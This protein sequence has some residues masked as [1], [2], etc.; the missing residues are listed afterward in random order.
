MDTI[1][2]RFFKL[3]R[4]VSSVEFYLPVLVTDEMT[5]QE[6][7]IELIMSATGYKDTI[8]RQKYKYNMRVL[9]T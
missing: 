6:N 8:L 9:F 3:C 2:A 1:Q 4:T 7:F 5:Q